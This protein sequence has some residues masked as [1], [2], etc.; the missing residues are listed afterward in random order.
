MAT[1]PRIGR[2]ERTVTRIVA[3]GAV[4]LVVLAGTLSSTAAQW[5]GTS[6]PQDP[7][8]PPLSQGL[9]LSASATSSQTKAPN[10][11][12]ASRSYIPVDPVAPYGE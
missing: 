10:A 6:I 3:A 8:S 4:A 5:D 2:I 1:T 9:D 7:V 12:M 11:S